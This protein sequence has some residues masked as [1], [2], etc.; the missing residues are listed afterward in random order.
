[1]LT[2]SE[3][4]EWRVHYKNRFDNRAF[5]GNL[6]TIPEDTKEIEELDRAISNLE[7]ELRD[8][9]TKRRIA[10]K[11]FA[12]S[13]REMMVRLSRNALGVRDEITSL[14]EEVY[15]RAQQ[16]GKLRGVPHAYDKV[17][18]FI[19]NG[20]YTNLHSTNR[21][22]SFGN[23][24]DNNRTFHPL[25]IE[26]QLV[27]AARTVMSYDTA[28]KGAPLYERAVNM[29]QKTWSRWNDAGSPVDKGEDNA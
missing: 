18:Q 15:E 24:Y 7:A 14:I 3:R 6:E 25:F 26:D 16:S 4:K 17:S 21:Y 13:R 19:K 23:G 10:Q 28:K 22:S 27:G 5:D 9:N 1:M 12:A 8:A 20:T 11:A 2:E 29:S